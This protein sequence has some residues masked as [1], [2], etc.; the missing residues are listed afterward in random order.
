MD[1]KIDMDKETQRCDERAQESG[2][3]SAQRIQIFT[4]G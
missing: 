4:G 1:G 3:R 2:C